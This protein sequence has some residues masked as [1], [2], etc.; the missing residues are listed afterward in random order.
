MQLQSDLHFTLAYTKG[1]FFS[2]SAIRFPDFQISKRK[3]FQITIL[4]VK[5]EFQ[6]NSD[7]F[8]LDFSSSSKTELWK[9][10]AEP[11]RAGAFQFS[12]W[13]WIY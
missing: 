1:G 7:E 3:I 5:F 2:E 6:A 8:E 11:S 10:W 12:S 4:I 13:N 9:F